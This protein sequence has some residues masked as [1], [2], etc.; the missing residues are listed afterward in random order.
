M[1]VVVDL[2][3][4]QGYAQCAFLAPDVFAM[5]GEEALLYDPQPDDTRRRTSCGRSAACPVKAITVDGAGSGGT[6]EGASRWR[7]TVPWSGSGAG[8]HRRRRRLPG[9]AA[10]RGDAAGGGLRR[11]P[12]M[13]GDEPYVRPAAAVQAGADWAGCAPTTPRCPG[14]ATLDAQWRLGVAGRRAG[15]GR[16]SGCASPTATRSEF[17]RLLIA[18][19]VRARPWPNEAEAALDGVF[20]LRTRDDAARLQPPARGGA[21]PGAGHRRRVHRLGDRLRVPGAGTWR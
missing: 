18:T 13:I 12:H 14:A 20:V 19:G 1:R 11:L 5:H 9:G 7:L 6:A 4:C 3:R 17:D 16:P 10:G 2:N 8:P 15:P 21:A